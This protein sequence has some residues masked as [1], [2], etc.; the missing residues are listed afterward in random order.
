MCNVSAPCPASHPCSRHWPGPP[1]AKLKLIAVPPPPHH[2]ICK[3]LSIIPSFSA[4]GPPMLVSLC[5]YG[6]PAAIQR[7]SPRPH[8]GMCP[9]PARASPAPFSNGFTLIGPTQ[10]GNLK[11]P[12]SPAEGSSRPD[13]AI[14]PSLS[15]PFS[16]ASEHAPS[17]ADAFLVPSKSFRDED[18]NLGHSFPRPLPRTP[19]RCLMATQSE[20]LRTPG[21]SLNIPPRDLDRPLYLVSVESRCQTQAWSRWA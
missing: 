4:D 12:G 2:G 17:T 15:R 13:S 18:I 21:G 6:R 9:S 8:A 10:Q 1:A 3:P 16:R 7:H 20:P 19:G 11:P 5:E 14:Y